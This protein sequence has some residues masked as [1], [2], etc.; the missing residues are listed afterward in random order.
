[1]TSSPPPP[2]PR[3]APWHWVDILV[4]LAGALLV[5][6]LANAAVS[7]AVH[8]VDGSLS[9][10]D[11]TSVEAMA[12]QLAFYGVAISITLLV[13]A[14]GRSVRVSELGWRRPSVNW[15]LASVPL[16]VAGLAIAG[17][18]VGISGSLLRTS[19]NQQCQ[20]VQQQYGHS[21]LLALPVVCI[22]APIVEETVFR[23]VIYRWLR[24]VLPLGYAMA[25]SA[26]VFAVA[27]AI[28]VLFLPLMGL[29]ILLAWIYERSRSLWPGVLVHALFNLVGI[30]D[31]LTA[32]RC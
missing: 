26:A 6:S 18:L 12:G 23:G 5:G 1:M 14:G 11:R 4:I 8:T 21:L 3:R 31:I 13:L 20:V 22:A 24:G 27:H 30:I 29:G 7:A 17:I 16:A 9:S 15:L 25:L 10:Q 32:T 2:L 19:D 28:S